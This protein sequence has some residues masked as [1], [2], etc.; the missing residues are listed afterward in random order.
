MVG[1]ANLG[2]ALGQKRAGPRHFSQPDLSDSGLRLC[3][4]TSVPGYPFFRHRLGWRGLVT[5]VAALACGLHPGSLPGVQAAPDNWVLPLPARP[6]DARG[7]K[8]IA[9]SLVGLDLAAREAVLE[10]EI[11]SGNVPD[12]LR[13]PVAVNLTS[14][15]NSVLFL[16]LPDYLAIG[17]EEDAFETPLTPMTAKRIAERLDCTLPTPGMVDAIFRAAELKLEPIPRPPGPGMTTVPVFLD[18]QEMVRRQREAVLAK[19]PWGTLTAGHHKDIVQTPLMADK[20][21]KVAIYGWHRPDGTPIQPLYTGHAATWVD[22]SHGVR[23]VRQAVSLDVQ[24]NTIDGMLADPKTAALLSAAP[25]PADPQIRLKT[26]LERAAFFCETLTTLEPEPGV[27][28]VINCPGAINPAQPV[29]LILYALPNGNTI[30]RTMGHL[31]GPGED[32]RFGIQH[33]AAQTRWLR[34]RQPAVTRI[35]AYLECAEKSWPAWGRKH[36]GS[37]ARVGAI[38]EK[39][40]QQIAMPRAKIVLTGH[41]GGGLIYLSLFKSA[42]VNL[43]QFTCIVPRPVQC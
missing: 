11:L 32:W 29:Q 4:I 17:K 16:A 7:G 43:Y 26:E 15:P 35:V 25:G 13:R 1:T 30:E 22:Y 42:L 39:L 10:R 24:P 9:E 2:G 18:Y 38:V 21:G 5:V 27:R 37:E 6:A 34:E 3:H 8:A 36:P 14:G 12:F 31:P 20:P 23:L 19:H 28:I 40:R 41:S 33:I